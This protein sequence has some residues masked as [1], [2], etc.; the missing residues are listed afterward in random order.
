MFLQL[1]ASHWQGMIKTKTQTN[2][3]LNNE[4]IYILSLKQVWTQKQQGDH[5]TSGHAGQVLSINPP[6][7]V[8]TPS[9]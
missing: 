1:A 7:T 4:M 8:T 6:I 9:Q 2:R 3:P 5:K